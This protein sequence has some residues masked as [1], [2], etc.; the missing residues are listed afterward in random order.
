MSDSAV[1]NLGRFFRGKG[2]RRAG[3]RHGRRRE[4]TGR[5]TL[6]LSVQTRLFCY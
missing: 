4:A 1:G 2:R 6:F 5:A 3:L